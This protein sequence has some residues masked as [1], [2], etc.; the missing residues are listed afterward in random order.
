M[1]LQAPAHNLAAP[2]Q[3]LPKAAAD[4]ERDVK[5]LIFIINLDQ[6]MNINGLPLRELLDL[7]KAL[8]TTRGELNLNLARLNQL[9]REIKDAEKL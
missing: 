7:N 5:E 8:Q 2:M 9:N 1:T 4:V 3:D 6:E